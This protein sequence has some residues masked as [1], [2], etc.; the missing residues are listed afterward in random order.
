MSYSI[1]HIY[2]DSRDSSTIVTHPDGTKRA[3]FT[4]H[5]DMPISYPG[6]LIVVARA[7]FSIQMSA[8]DPPTPH[9]HLPPPRPTVK[10]IPVSTTIFTPDG[11]PFT[12]THVTRADLEQ[13]RDLREV[14]QGTWR[15][16][17]SGV[18][19][20]ILISDDDGRVMSGPA[21]VWIAIE[22]TVTSQSAGLLGSSSGGTALTH[23]YSFDLFRVGQFVATVTLPDGTVSD[24]ATL[25]LIDPD[26][27]IVASDSHG[28]LRF[29]VSLR[30]LDKSRDPSGNV[31]RWS[32]EFVTTDPTLAETIA[33]TVIGTAR[34]RC[35]CFR[36]AS[37]SCSGPMVRRSPS[38]VKM[39]TVGPWPD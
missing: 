29:E 15:Y 26:G 21:A 36:A 9:T 35:T 5:G 1:E 11:L 7:E 16:E 2:V 8:S 24:T 30:S 3:R 12:G 23:V 33:A 34:V 37:T 27:A 19:E 32:L 25:A 22:E 10:Q 14:S 39:S 18:S 6:R 17:T 4:A 13:F 28:T 38:T 31:R 20:A